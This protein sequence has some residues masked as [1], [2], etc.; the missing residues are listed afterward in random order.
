VFKMVTML[1][2]LNVELDLFLGWVG[3]LG[4]VVLG[5]RILKGGR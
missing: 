1:I 5:K 3:G 4:W 2:E